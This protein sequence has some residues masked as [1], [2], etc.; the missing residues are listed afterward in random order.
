MS[1]SEKDIKKLWG[2]AA[3]ICSFPGCGA[4]CIPFVDSNDPTLIGE[5]AHVIAKQPLGPRGQPSGGSDDYTNLILL[6]PT[7]HRLVDKAPEG[8]YPKVTILK[9]KEDH[10]A[11]VRSWS[12]VPLFSSKREL[13]QRILR[14][15]IE[16]HAIWKIYGPESNTALSDPQSNVA[17]LWTL[18]KLA[19]ILPRNKLIANLVQQNAALFT[20]AEYALCA[21]FVEHA[22]GFESSA[23]DRKDRVPRFPKQF[24]EMIHHGAEE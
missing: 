9:W 4:D 2:L 8:T 13:C 17:R 10:E 3:G 23:Y 19:H 21:E 11:S 14:L 22:A 24:E 5:M 1:I 20:S 12:V 16:N 7:H 6:C 15:L 18:R